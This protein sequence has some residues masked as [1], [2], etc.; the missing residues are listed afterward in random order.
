[1]QIKGKAAFDP[2]T[3]YE[4]ANLRSEKI[5]LLKLMVA[6]AYAV[7]NHL[8]REYEAD[9]SEF[10]GLLPD[11]FAQYTA[12][13]RG[14]VDRQNSLSYLTVSAADGLGEGGSTMKAPAPSAK[15][16][17]KTPLLADS[18]DTIASFH[19]IGC[20]RILPLPLMCVLCVPVFFFFLRSDIERP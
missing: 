6:F 5:R 13:W 17:Q 1:M 11:D 7:K 2:N 4:G 12:D 3:A 10:D 20:D 16:T 19:P 14:A 15:S 8:R 9:Y 18:N